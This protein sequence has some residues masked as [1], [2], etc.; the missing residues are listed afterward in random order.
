MHAKET[1]V[2]R[3]VADFTTILAADVLPE[4]RSVRV[5]PHVDFPTTCSPRRSV[6]TACTLSPFHWVDRSASLPLACGI[7]RLCLVPYVGVRVALP[8]IRNQ[9]RELGVKVIA[10]IWH[11]VGPRIGFEGCPT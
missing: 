11:A 1:R 2:K 3:Q 4:S 9:L 6:K 8:T 7:T 5:F 10:V